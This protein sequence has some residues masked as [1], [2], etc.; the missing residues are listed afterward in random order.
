MT[1]KLIFVFILVTIGMGLKVTEAGVN[2]WHFNNIGKIKSLSFV[3]N[4]ISFVSEINLFG[5]L[6][7]AS[8][9][10]DNRIVIE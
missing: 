3:K 2:D 6:D 10:I 8:G 7:K 9:Q 5:Q 1:A 4:K